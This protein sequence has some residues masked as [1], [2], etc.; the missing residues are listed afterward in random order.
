MQQDFQPTS[1]ATSCLKCRV[2]R[3]TLI[4]SFANDVLRTIGSLSPSKLCSPPNI[5]RGGGVGWRRTKP[6]RG[7]PKGPFHARALLHPLLPPADPSAPSS[8]VEMVCEFGASCVEVDGLAHCECP[9]PL[10]R[11]ANTSKVSRGR[12]R[13]KERTWPVE[14]VASPASRNREANLPGV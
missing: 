13:R 7:K 5:G 14:Q 4:D 9:S 6:C 10:C 1:R 12:I 8:C 2:T 3:V 11:E